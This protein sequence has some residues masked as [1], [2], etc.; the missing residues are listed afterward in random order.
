M[1]ERVAI[2]GVG[3]TAAKRRRTDVSEVELVNEAVRAALADSQLTIKDIDV[4]IVGNM[5]YFE[6]TFLTDQWL[7]EGLGSYLKSGMK[8]ND[9]GNTGA[10][11]FTTG[12]AHVASGLFN[13]AIVV[14]FEKQDEGSYGGI[15]MRSEDA[16]FNVSSGGGRA[17]GAMWGTA[18][19]VLDRGS[20]TEEH[21]AK[22][23]VKAAECARRNPFAHLKLNLTV[24]D[25]MKSEIIMAPVRMLH[26]CPTTVGA[27]AVIVASE[28]KAK[29]ITNKPVWVKDYA[30]YHSGLRPRMGEL[31]ICIG[32]AIPTGPWFRWG[33]AHS[34]AKLYKRN[35]IT[36]PR[37]QVDIVESYSPSSWHEV[38]YD[39]GVKLCEPGK[40]WKLV[41]QQATW[42]NG[43]IPWDP[44]G[45][46]VST[47]AI[48]AS[49]LVRIAEASLQIRGDAGERQVPK[50]VNQA[51][52][53]AQGADHFSTSV[54]LTKNL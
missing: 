13:T 52:A 37:K 29:K 11:V 3:E 24:E 16:F 30:C 23:R 27:C 1:A 39:E 46:V 33:V 41:E 4:V 38:D 18:V 36:N 12:V 15:G 8:V 25:V 21:I 31:E 10:T 5:E 42:P 53:F 20:A 40:A 34:V 26:I 6:G 47:N 49:G 50:N 35:G 2:V 45:G 44:S 7:S 43:D 9:A 51:L 32:A 19:S 48:G 54:L 22:V 14:G 17:M 28:G